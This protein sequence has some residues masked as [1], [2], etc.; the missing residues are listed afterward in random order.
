MA[1]LEI[2]IFAVT[3]IREHHVSGEDDL[4]IVPKINGVARIAHSQLKLKFVPRTSE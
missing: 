4:K 3:L 2:I 1:I